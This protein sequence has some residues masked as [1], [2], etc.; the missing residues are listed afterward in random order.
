VTV[1]VAWTAWHR[2]PITRKRSLDRSLLF[3]P[4]FLAFNAFMQS[5][6]SSTLNA[7]ALARW[8][9]QKD[10]NG[11]R[12]QSSERRERRGLLEVEPEGDTSNWSS[13][14]T[15]SSSHPEFAS[16]DFPHATL[17][18]PP[19]IPN[20]PKFVHA[21]PPRCSSDDYLLRVL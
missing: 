10:D 13:M 15:G 20:F 6:Q 4:L 9:A 1:V 12:E 18:L 16:F 5:A 21:P 2:R 14:Q 11:K 3:F 8:G 17:Q 7:H 19:G